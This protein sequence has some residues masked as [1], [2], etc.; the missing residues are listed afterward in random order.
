MLLPACLW[1]CLLCMDAVKLYKHDDENHKHGKTKAMETICR[2]GVGGPHDA[3]MVM[4]V[5]G[6]SGWKNNEFNSSVVALDSLQNIDDKG[7]ME[8][9]IFHDEADEFPRAD[10]EI[11]LGFAQS[12]PFKRKACATK[13]RFAKFPAGMKESDPSPWSK[14]TKWGYEHMIRFFFVDLFDPMEGMLTGFKYWSRMDTDSR[15]HKTSNFIALFDKDPELG[16]LHNWL[17]ADCEE[18]GGDTMNKF[19]STYAQKDGI[20]RQKLQALDAGLLAGR[21]KDECTG[22]YY[23]NLEA[24]RISA[25][26][27]PQALE[28]M[29]SVVAEKGIYRFRWGDAMLRRLTVELTGIKTES[30]EGHVRY[31]KR[32]L[33]TQLER[34]SPSTD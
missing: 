14:R 22:G 1:A 12:G 16:Y 32:V 13:L 11:L 18:G 30:I 31:C 5:A 19:A 33:C 3:V 28:W 4:L 24:G 27:T 6:P 15:W 34:E 10:L 26:Q 2:E 20:D 29:H 9:R 17:N 23:N 7:R 8:V 21:G 25:F